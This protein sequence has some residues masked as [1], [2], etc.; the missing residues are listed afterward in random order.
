MVFNRSRLTH[1][2]WQDAVNRMHDTRKAQVA[3]RDVSAI[4]N[5][6]GA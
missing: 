6:L 4:R 1:A 2:L 3:A 5:S